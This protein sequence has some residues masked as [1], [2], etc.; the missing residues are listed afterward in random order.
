MTEEDRRKRKRLEKRIDDEY[1]H[2]RTHE[3]AIQNRK[4]KIRKLEKILDEMP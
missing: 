4:V 3:A 1:K 2:I